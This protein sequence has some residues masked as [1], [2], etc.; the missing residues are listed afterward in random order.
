[1]RVLVTGAAGFV[2]SAVV[3]V[4]ADRGDEVC[5]LVRSAPPVP[6][7]RC[8]YLDGDLL[9]ARA[10]R[11]L[12]RDAAPDVIVHAAIL[13]DPAAALADRD[14]A[15][16][17]YVDATRNICDAANETGAALVYISTDW[18]FDGTQAPADERTPPNPINLYGFLK[19]ASELVV[20]ER[21]R[22][23]PGSRP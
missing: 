1:V 12:L 4:A 14:L 23:S 19:A 6:D 10:T 21:S 18:V 3:A 5:G 13:N 17:A 16:A 8:R 2:G 20:L 9:D 15:W 11:A 7:P 22:S